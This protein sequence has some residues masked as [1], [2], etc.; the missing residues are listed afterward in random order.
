MEGSTTQVVLSLEDRLKRAMAE[1]DTLED[2]QAQNGELFARLKARRENGEDVTTE[3]QILKEG[4]SDVESDL[5]GAYRRVGRLTKDL[6]E[7]GPTPVQDETAPSN[8][9]EVV[10]NESVE[11]RTEDAKK[12]SEKQLVPEPINENSIKF[13]AELFDAQKR[14]AWEVGQTIS[15]L[16]NRENNNFSVS[17]IRNTSL[18]E[19]DMLKNMLETKALGIGNVSL[20]LDK[21]STIFKLSSESKR[22]QA[23][24]D[25]RSLEN[26]IQSAGKMIVALENYKNVIARGQEENPKYKPLISKINQLKDAVASKKVSTTISRQLLGNYFNR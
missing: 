17:L 5:D 18:R 11:A 9:K 22:G 6:N 13:E 19:L 24:E 15:L 21:M 16:K 2:K 8:A 23:I 12:E 7:R 26:F 3:I 10:V 25:S 4:I 14:F 20:A 1:R